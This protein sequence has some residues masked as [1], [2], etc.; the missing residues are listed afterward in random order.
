[1]KALLTLQ[2]GTFVAYFDQAPTGAVPP[3]VP[4]DFSSTSFPSVIEN[5]TVEQ[6]A[7]WLEEELHISKQTL[8]KIPLNGR[9]LVKVQIT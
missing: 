5:W 7:K 6:T 4:Y 8:A 3:P 1:V 9:Q 2:E